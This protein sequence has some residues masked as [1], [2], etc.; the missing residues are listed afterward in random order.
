MDLNTV[1]LAFQA[2]LPDTKGKYTQIVQP[3]VSNCIYDKSKRIE[4]EH[5]L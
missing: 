3:V 1:R 4:K 5:I 2:F